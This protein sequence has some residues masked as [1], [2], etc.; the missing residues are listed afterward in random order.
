[1]RVDLPLSPRGHV[2]HSVLLLHLVQ[3]T[4]RALSVVL[5]RHLAHRHTSHHFRYLLQR[6]LVEYWG[7]DLLQLLVALAQGYC[8]NFNWPL[9]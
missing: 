8:S 5:P 7:L 2:P 6:V 1:M 4:S 9:P 3:A